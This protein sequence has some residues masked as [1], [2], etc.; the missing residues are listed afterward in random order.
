MAIEIRQITKYD[1]KLIK[2]LFASCNEHCPSPDE[3]FFNSIDNIL[4]V[5]YSNNVPAG[6]LYSHIL[7][8]LNETKPKMFLYSIDVFEPFKRKGIGTK[9]IAQ[10]K[11]ISKAY[12]CSEII[13]LT[14]SSNKPAMKFYRSVGGQQKNNDDV[15][16]VIKKL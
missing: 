9:L 3:K 2:T 11:K 7:N 13:I 12:H 5:A 8:S 16:F 14:N 1:K 15:M 4:L 10:L 6:F